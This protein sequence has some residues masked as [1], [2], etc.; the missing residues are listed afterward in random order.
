MEEQRQIEIEDEKI[1]ILAKKV[2][3]LTRDSLMVNARF[4]DTAL[5]RVSFQETMNAKGF[6]TDGVNLYYDPKSLLMIYKEEPNRVLR[7]VLH[8]LFHCIFLHHFQYDKLEQENWDLATD[9]AVENAVLELDLYP[10]K[11]KS[12][13]EARAKLRVL[14]EDA[15]GLTA[16][17]L[18]RYF[19]RE[20]LSLQARE[21]YRSIFERDSHIRWKK[22]EE[23][24]ISAQDWKKISERIKADLKSFSKA[25]GSGNSESIEKNLGEATREQY[26][27]EGLLRRF[28]VLGEDLQLSEDEFDYVY[29]TYG[30]STYGNRPLIEPLEYRDTKKIRDFV[31]AIDTSASCQ[32]KIVQAFLRRTYEVLKSEESFF[33]KMNVHILQ[34]DNE[35]REDNKITSQEE[36]EQFIRNGKLTGFGSTDFRPVF[37]Y[38][39]QLIE[40][41][42]VENLKGLIYFTD[43]YGVYP[44][45][46]PDYEVVFAF[47]QE[48]DRAP[49]VPSWAVKV[50]LS[51]E[52]LEQKG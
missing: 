42:Q 31:I 40:T 24:A 2:L 51:E 21:E 41:R 3:S 26:D 16:E 43:G 33:K 30:L 1:S 18:Y 35:I 20:P 5:A 8:M 11:L 44:E 17:K 22:Q 47:L 34:C 37:S 19:R 23:L 39:D 14:R 6:G 48:D 52:E 49:E 13:E 28:T 25:R 7:L 36:F 10:G 32:G 46:M 29:Y 15:G 9:L 38:I 45:K 27:Y 50:V 4:L 12:D